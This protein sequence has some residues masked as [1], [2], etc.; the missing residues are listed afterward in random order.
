LHLLILQLYQELV[1]VQEQLTIAL[2]DHPLHTMLCT[3]MGAD[4]VVEVTILMH[5]V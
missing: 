3:Q 4:L 1:E 2:K 5:S